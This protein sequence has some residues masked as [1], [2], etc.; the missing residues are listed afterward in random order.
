M[1]FY[2]KQRFLGVD[3][4]LAGRTFRTKQSRII[5]NVTQDQDFVAPDSG[6]SHKY[7]SMICAALVL[8][9]LC[10]GV[11]TIDG[12][13]ENAFIDDDLKI[14]ETYAEI[15]AMTRLLQLADALKEEYDE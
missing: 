5:P 2:R 15:A 10:V 6:Y 14:A 7:L 3:A 9:D 4:S 8:G 11:I 1:V 12:L 13:R